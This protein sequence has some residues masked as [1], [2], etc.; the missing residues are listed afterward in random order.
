MGHIEGEGIWPLTWPRGA[1]NSLTFTCIKSERE[2]PGH[3][4]GG[5]GGGGGG[6]VLSPLWPSSP[7]G[8]GRAGAGGGGG[9]GGGGGVWCILIFGPLPQWGVI[10]Q[11]LA[12]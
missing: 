9:G 11:G 10:I 7:G 3:H 2:C 5:G 8:G 6:L 4:G 1:E 12:I